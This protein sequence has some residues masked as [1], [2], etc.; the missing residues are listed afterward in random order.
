MKNEM[1]AI[2]IQPLM[3]VLKAVRLMMG[4]L[5]LEDQLP[6]LILVLSVH[7]LEDLYPVIKEVENQC[8]VMG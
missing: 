4:M 5:V 6:H 3:D 7:Q 1:M 2:K 8:E